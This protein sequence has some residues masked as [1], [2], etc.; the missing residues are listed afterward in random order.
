MPRC[1]RRHSEFRDRCWS[2]GSP[3]ARFGELAASLHG[4]SQARCVIGRAVR[5]PSIAR[6]LSDHQG[7][8]RSHCAEV[9]LRGRQAFSYRPA[10]RTACDKNEPRLWI[11]FV[12]GG[13]GYGVLGYGEKTSHGFSVGEQP[14]FNGS[15]RYSKAHA[16]YGIG[17]ISPSPKRRTFILIEITEREPGRVTGGVVEATHACF[18]CRDAGVVDGSSLDGQAGE[19]PSHDRFIYRSF[20]E[21]VDR[22]PW[23]HKSKAN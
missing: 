7:V 17:E 20:Y 2:S 1:P 6:E 21:A 23:H 15:H 5:G 4:A 10:A 11:A 3:L 22:Q 16:G 12:F 9:P 18:E 13:D 14:G 8:L 19:N